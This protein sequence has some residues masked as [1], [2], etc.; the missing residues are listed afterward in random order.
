MLTALVTLAAAVAAFPADLD[1]PAAVFAVVA[2]AVAV[3]VVGMSA[4][5]FAAVAAVIAVAVTAVVGLYAVPVR[6]VEAE[7]V[8]QTFL[9][10]KHRLV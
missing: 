9:L 7:M 10:H 4:A 2:I 6:P 5:A 8:M 1:K 3:S